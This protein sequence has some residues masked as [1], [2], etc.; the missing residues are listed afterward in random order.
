MRDILEFEGFLLR[1]RAVFNVVCCAPGRK[2]AAFFA[3][4]LCGCTTGV[5]VWSSVVGVCFSHSF[6]NHKNTH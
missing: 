3:L 2:G 4:I 1:G 6:N 5:G